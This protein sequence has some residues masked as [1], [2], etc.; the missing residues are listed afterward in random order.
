MLWSLIQKEW[1]A[2]RRDWHGVL[3]L[4]VM[5]SAFIL[6]MSLALR[7]TFQTQLPEQ[8]RWHFVDH[9]R[10]E[11]SRQLLQQIAN[12]EHAITVADTADIAA[13]MRSGEIILL[14]EV[15]QGFAEA[16]HK[17]EQHEA[18]VL[19]LSRAGTPLPISAGFQANVQRAFALVQAQNLL[20]QLSPLADS[21]GA[22]LPSADQLSQSGLLAFHSEQAPQ[23]PMTAV[24]QSVPAWLIFSMFFVVIPIA[25]IVIAEQ[26]YGT[27]KRLRSLQ[28]PMSIFLLSKIIPFY[29]IGLVQT[30]LMLLVGHYLVPLLGG[31]ALQMTAA[32]LPLLVLVSFTSLAAIAFALL[33]ACLA[34]STEQATTF[35]GTANIIMAALGG[36][37][38]PKMVMP[39]EMQILSN[40]SPM[41]WPLEGFLQL[42]LHDGSWPQIAA[43]LLKLSGFAAISFVVA[44]Q[45]LQRRQR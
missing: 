9:D 31:D 30:A 6:I 7:D 11:A 29:L 44:I 17:G 39:A 40:W 27:L 45:L 34:H 38:V 22:R 43:A 25:N 42:F 35:G 24:Q 1:R 26:Q 2:L 36:V 8:I 15:R 32:W 18:K 12:Y 13:K 10:S 16:L 41:A 28:V 21:V 3:V 4:F 37:M 23:V 20:Q 19:V 33:V 14:V 5:P